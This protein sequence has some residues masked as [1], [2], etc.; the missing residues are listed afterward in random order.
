MFIAD[1]EERATDRVGATTADG[2]TKPLTAVRS[3]VNKANTFIL[4]VVLEKQTPV[5]LFSKDVGRGES[6]CYSVF[7]CVVETS[8]TGKSNLSNAGS[9]TLK[10]GMSGPGDRGSKFG[11]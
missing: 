1:V 4:Y 10:L 7:L 2:T 9:A 3:S 8:C 11:S 5:G 6:L